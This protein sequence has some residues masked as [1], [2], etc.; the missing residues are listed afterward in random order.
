MGPAIEIGAVVVMRC[1][2]RIHLLL[3]RPL[4]HALFQTLLTVWITTFLAVNE[5]LGP[6]T[7]APGSIQSAFDSAGVEFAQRHLLL[8]I[9]GA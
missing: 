6:G 8:A 4:V 3:Q 9:T 2:G 5:T 7:P 1:S